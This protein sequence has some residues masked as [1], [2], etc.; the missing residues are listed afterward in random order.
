MNLD[1]RVREALR[2]KIIAGE[3][4]GGFHLSELKISKEYNVSRT[5]VREAL[6]AL[7]ADGLVE[8]VPHR[9]A[10]VSDVP[11]HTKED[12][13]QMFGQF[14]ALAARM[15]AQ[16]ASI[17]MMMDLETALSFASDASQTK[18][19]FTNALQAM[20]ELFKKTSGSATLNEVIS[21]LE[22]RMDMQT[23]WANAF[24][25]KQEIQQQI[26]VLLAAMKRQ[27][28]DTAEK[29]MRQIMTLA[30]GGTPAQEDSTEAPFAAATSTTS[31]TLNN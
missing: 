11:A 9:G 28:G 18:E 26:S 21:L 17:D 31:A 15:T 16:K 3:L 6:C 10:F 23:F 14:M 19:G 8:M 25:A 13:T 24:T 30:M 2:E 29:T 7:A 22:R 27:K 20:T 12:Q 4:G 5:P 1:E